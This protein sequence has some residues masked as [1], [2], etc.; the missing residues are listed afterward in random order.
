MGPAYQSSLN[1]PKFASSG[2]LERAKTVR[3]APDYPLLALTFTMLGF[4]LLMV[5]STTG[6]LALERFNDA[7]YFVKRQAFAALIGMVGLLL[8][9]R[10]PLST[11]KRLSPWAGIGA[12]IF[13]ALPMIPG[14]GDRAGGATRWVNL[15][16][17]RFQP[18]E[19]AKLLFVIYLA[20][21][22][23]RHETK[24]RSW[25][26]GII[27]PNLILAP[28]A[29]LFLLKPDFGSAVVVTAVSIAMV[30]A[31]GA[32][33][34]R[35]AVCGAGLIGCA[36]LL[37]LS[38]PYRL[39]RVVTFL[40][41]W[42]D[43]QGSGY[44]LIQSLIAIGSGRIT[45]AGIGASQQK[46]FF[47]PAAHT[48]FIFSVIAEELGFVGCVCVVACFIL[49]LWRGFVV[50]SR[51]AEHTFAFA[52]ACGLTLLVV[53]PALLNFGVASGL[54][55]TKGMVLPFIAYGGSSLIASLATVGLLLMVARHA[56]SGEL[57]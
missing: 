10:M 2:A 56:H 45:G 11:L 42:D 4:G 26:H 57:G 34:R 37:I 1:L 28:V 48:D 32:N 19:I 54:L 51:V 44:Q 43:A 7:W 27:I 8:L 41:P 24:L 14:L 6:V 18:G 5:Y 30:A 49:F 55:P 15:A 39:K 21:Y 46:L 50:A 53:L 13:L 35:L 16:G 23:A 20:G 3:H 12:V 47:L 38:S 36:A 52:L 40:A 31:A 9:F 25:T 17:V 33:L 29:L 22:L